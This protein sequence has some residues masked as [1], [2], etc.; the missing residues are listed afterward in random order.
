MF[1]HS[2]MLCLTLPLLCAD[3]MTNVFSDVIALP[4]SLPHQSCD[5]I[6]CSL[7]LACVNHHPSPVFL[8]F[9]LHQPFNH[10]VIHEPVH[11]IGV[12]TPTIH[13][14][15]T[16]RRIPAAAANKL[17]ALFKHTLLVCKIIYPVLQDRSLASTH[18]PQKN[19]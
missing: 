5:N 14:F 7:A 15:T 10:L 2:G 19:L 3:E 8:H 1:A 13:N 17:N 16:G 12:L 18:L 4:T 11:H 9:S 6:P